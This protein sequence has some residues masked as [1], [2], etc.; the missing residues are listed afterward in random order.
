MNLLQTI[1]NKVTQSKQCC[2]YCGKSYKTR[3][4]LEKHLLL[5]ELIYKRKNTSLSL[6][7]EHDIPSQKKIYQL[8]L[9][10]GQK[11][12]RLEEKVEEINKYVIKKK[13]KINIIEWLTTNITPNIDFNVFTEKINITNNHVEFLFNNSIIDTFNEIFN[14]FYETNDLENPIFAFIQKNN[15]FYIYDKIEANHIWIELSR[16]KFIKFLNKIQ[17]KISKAFYEWKKIHTQELNDIENLSTLYD[18]ALIKLMSVDFKQENILCKIKTIIYAKIK[19]DIKALV[20][21]EFE[22]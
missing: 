8:L 7:D 20:E 5:C 17:M 6:E 9:E 4:N 13:K 12:N 22:F 14:S 19:T 18:K 21:Y 10:L 2:I 16:E 3:T 1:P 11:Y 15:T